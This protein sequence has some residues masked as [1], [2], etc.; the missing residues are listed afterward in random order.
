VTYN[1]TLSMSTISVTS[2]IQ[3]V[4]GKS[5]IVSIVMLF[6]GGRG[7]TMTSRVMCTDD[8]NSCTVPRRKISGSV[9]SKIMATGL[10]TLGVTVDKDPKDA[11][12]GI[13]YRVVINDASPTDGSPNY[14]ISV[15]TNSLVTA[16]GATATLVTKEILPGVT[17]GACTG[18]FE[19]PTQQALTIGQNYFARVFSFNMVG[20]SLPKISA[21]SEK[22]QVVPGAPTSVV[23]TNVNE[24]NL[25]VNFNPP[26]S[27]GGSTITKYYIQYSPNSDFESA[28]QAVVGETIVA[29]GPPFFKTLTGLTKGVDYY[30]RVAAVNSQGTGPWTGSSPSFMNPHTTPSAPSGVYLKVTGTSM[31]TVSFD[32]PADNGGDVV[33]MYRVKWDIAVNQDSSTEMPDKGS[34]DVSAANYKSYTIQYLRPGQKYYVQVQA[35]NSAGTGALAIPS[36]VFASPASQVPGKPQSIAAHTGAVAGSITVVYYQSTVPW[37]GVQCSGTVDVVYECPKAHGQMI[38][39]SNGGLEVQEYQICYSEKPNFQNDYD[40]GC[41]V[42]TEM[43]TTI[44]GL[45]P[46]RNYH[47]RILARNAVGSGPYCAYTGANCIKELVPISAIAKS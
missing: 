4:A 37:H 1:S 44:T 28:M 39:Q 43:T 38:P 27:D 36:P 13:T 40:K 16:S 46:G 23:L 7:T 45:T 14:Q 2:A 21:N 47:F 31:V 34:V 25:R 6:S 8:S 22:P 33:T 12:G 5:S 41:L 3:L 24:G 17:Y 30:I 35:K 42:T 15:G 29:D 10:F 20:F 11:T 32:E 9:Q 19:L 18:T 26:A